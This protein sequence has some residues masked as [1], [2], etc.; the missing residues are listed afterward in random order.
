MGKQEWVK[1]P[2]DQVSLTARSPNDSRPPPVASGVSVLVI[3]RALH[4]TSNGSMNP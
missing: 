3:I 1:Q 4:A 2:E